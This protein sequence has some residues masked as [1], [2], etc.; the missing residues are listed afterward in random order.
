[1]IADLPAEPLCQQT[2]QSV[3]ARVI[4]TPDPGLDVRFG[5]SSWGFTLKSDCFDPERFRAFVLAHI[6]HAPEDFC[7][8]GVDVSVGYPEGCGD[9]PTD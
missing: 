9:A 3:R 2:S 6:G 5:A 1:M 4:L 7:S 8:D